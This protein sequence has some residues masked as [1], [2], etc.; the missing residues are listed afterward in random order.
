LNVI[1]PDLEAN[2]LTLFTLLPSSDTTAKSKHH[3]HQ[4]SSFHNNENIHLKSSLD[5][6][7]QQI[8]WIALSCLTHW[9]SQTGFKLEALGNLTLLSLRRLLW[10]ALG[11]SL[12]TLA[13]AGK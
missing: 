8:C 2:A 4:Y 5:S 13:F 10:H 9:D 1:Q 11:Y 3:H 7:A 12:K 6:I